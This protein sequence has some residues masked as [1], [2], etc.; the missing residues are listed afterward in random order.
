M[1]IIA[2]PRG[3]LREA[4]A[5]VVIGTLKRIIERDGKVTPDAVLAEASAQDSDLHRFFEWDDST[6]AVQHRLH[7]A[8]QLVRSVVFL[9]V[10]SNEVA[11]ERKFVFEAK[12]VQAT[13]NVQVSKPVVAMTL[14]TSSKSQDKILAVAQVIEQAVS[15]IR[16]EIDVIDELRALRKIVAA[17]RE[18]APTVGVRCT[19]CG[20][21]G[22]RPGGQGCTSFELR[23]SRGD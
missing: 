22:H 2:K 17:L 6:A 23:R 11:K 16:E 14:P 4:D 13:M 18:K 9:P 10:C 12:P 5:A 1:E 7:Q 21:T 8:R 19:K 15:S 20:L 3:G